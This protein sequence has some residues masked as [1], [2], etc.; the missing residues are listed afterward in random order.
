M[1]YFYQDAA[2]FK[3][4]NFP[5]NNLMKKIISIAAICP[6]WKEPTCKTEMISQLLFCEEAIVLEEEK[7]FT[8]VRCVLDGYE[9]WCMNNQ[10]AET[11]ASK[12][13]KLKGYINKNGTGAL[14]NNSLIHLPL[15]AP[16]YENITTATYKIEYP[17]NDYLHLEQIKASSI[18]AEKI[19][20][21]FLNTP[22]LWG[23]K[24]SYGIDC[25]GLTQ[26]VFK[27]MGIPLQRDAWQQVTQGETVDF[28][29]QAQCGDLA[30]FD[31][32]AGEIIHVGM[33]LNSSSVI[34]ASGYVRIDGM[35]NLGIINAVNG[36]RTHR[37]RII[38]RMF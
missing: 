37:L 34:H 7:N 18:E 27:M 10:I 17:G 29:Q 14:I 25:S 19:A 5:A 32:E 13:I 30:L 9:G 12:A 23:G 38:K 4:H 28:L 21:L 2:F 36:K 33:L 6:L 35:D 26:K 20:M 3:F 11:D 24:S 8:L 15:A 16:V 22:Y 31:N 1:I